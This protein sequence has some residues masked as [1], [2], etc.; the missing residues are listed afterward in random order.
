MK[1]KA[2]AA[3]GPRKG[4][5]TQ[6]GAT[7]PALEARAHIDAYPTTG[8]QQAWLAVVGKLGKGANALAIT[9]ELGVSRRAVVHQMEALEKK[10]LA[11]PVYKRV[12][13]RYVLTEAGEAALEPDHGEADPNYP[14]H[15]EH[16]GS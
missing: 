9:R 16:F 8:R 13:S 1:T 12:V 15:A 10:G 2:R 6:G 14:P 7:N 4:K 11:R 3:R 5:P